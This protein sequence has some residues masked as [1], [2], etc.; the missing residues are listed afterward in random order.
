M[1]SIFIIT[2]CLTFIMGCFLQEESCLDDN[3]CADSS[4]PIETSD[5]TLTDTVIQDTLVVDTQT[6]DTVI[7]DP[8]LSCYDRESIISP[9]CANGVTFETNCDAV[10]EGFDDYLPGSCPEEVDS[11]AVCPELLA[12]APTCEVNEQLVLKD[13]SHLWYKR[14]SI[15]VQQALDST[16]PCDGHRYE[17]EVIE[18]CEKLPELSNVDCGNLEVKLFEDKSSG[19]SEYRCVSPITWD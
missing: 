19:C 11:N 2:A 5:T 15:D 1:R 14:K 17:C 3:T 12:K 7:I 9:V 18:G 8:H 10:A 13:V 16:D 4:Q 6:V